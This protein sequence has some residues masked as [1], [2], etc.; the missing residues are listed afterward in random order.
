MNERIR[1]LAQQADIYAV[2]MNPEED[3]YGRSANTEKFEQDRDTKFA[4]LIVQECCNQITQEPFNA[5][6]AS[7]FI[8][9]QFGIGE[10]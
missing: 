9:Q 6:A 5:G 2:K 1:L 3:S 10:L 7:Q 4:E 8:K